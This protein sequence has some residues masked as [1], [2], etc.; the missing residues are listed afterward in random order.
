MSAA[1]TTA[2]ASPA[3]RPLPPNGEARQQFRVRLADSP[4]GLTNVVQVFS[5]MNLRLDHLGYARDE[6]GSATATLTA[7]FRAD[8]RTADLIFRKL[9]RLIEVL[10]AMAAPPGE[11]A[12]SVAAPSVWERPW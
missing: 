8:A 3:G 12:P 6:A 7:W 1:I 2:E 9:T 4:G 10:E 5:S 11:E